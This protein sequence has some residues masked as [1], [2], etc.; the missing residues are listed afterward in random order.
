MARGGLTGHVVEALVEVPV[1]VALGHNGVKCIVQVERHIGRRVLVDRQ[2]ARGVENEEMSWRVC[3]RACVSPGE[4]EDR[5]GR[6]GLTGADSKLFDFRHLLHQLS[7]DDVTTAAL[8]RNFHD[9]LNPSIGR[10]RGV[11]GGG[12]RCL[13]RATATAVLDLGQS[14]PGE[15]RGSRGRRRREVELKLLVHRQQ[16][17]RLV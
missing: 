16:V 6:G 17:E 2:T 4:T 11:V 9:F 15:G 5:G 3:V 12:W 1:V 13:D 10:P 8:V 7:R 14:C